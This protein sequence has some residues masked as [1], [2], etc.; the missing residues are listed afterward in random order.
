[1]K[2]TPKILVIRR[3]KHGGVIDSWYFDQK[4]AETQLSWDEAE[5]PHD[6]IGFY[7]DDIEVGSIPWKE[8]R[9][10]ERAIKDYK[11]IDVPCEWIE[12]A[13]SQGLIE[14]EV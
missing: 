9:E 5:D 14:A 13:V 1:M 12:W 7:I 3:L 11:E 4:E 2:T 6:R 10:V 8:M